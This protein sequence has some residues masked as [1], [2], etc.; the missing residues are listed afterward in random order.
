M[1]VVPRMSVL[2]VMCRYTW[3]TLGLAQFTPFGTVDQEWLMDDPH[4][5][6]RLPIWSRLLGNRAVSQ[7]RAQTSPLLSFITLPRAFSSRLSPATNSRSY[8]PQNESLNITTNASTG[9]AWLSRLQNFYNILLLNRLLSNLQPQSY[10][11]SG[12][13]PSGYTTSGNNMDHT[14]GLRNLYQMALWTQMIGNQ[15]MSSSASS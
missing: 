8:R 10:D 9:N 15:D 6:D 5:T 2:V 12:S 11:T 1:T 4:K 13:D 14:H 3:F 7:P